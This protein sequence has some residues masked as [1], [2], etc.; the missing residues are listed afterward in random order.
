[1]NEMIKI[2]VASETWD[3]ALAHCQQYFPEERVANHPSHRFWVDG[4]NPN[5]QGILGELAFVQWLGAVSVE[6]YLNQ[7]PVF[8]RDKGKDIVVGKYRID[9][10]TPALRVLP[11]P[12]HKFLIE[13]ALVEM[14]VAD[15]YVFQ[16]IITPEMR[17]VYLMGFATPRDIIA[18]GEKKIKGDT[19]YGKVTAGY[20]GYLVSADLLGSPEELK[21][22][23]KG[24]KVGDTLVSL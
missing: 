13:D 20:N 19:I 11:K 15:L 5:F 6:D 7:R 22:M 16:F 18:L 24:L 12:Y 14:N 21:L 2:D 17:E 4:T 10:K 3:L 1:M 8:K 23:L 9:I